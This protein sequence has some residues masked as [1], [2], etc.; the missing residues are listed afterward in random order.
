MVSA[1]TKR[2]RRYGF[3]ATLKP[4]F[5]LVD[6][7]TPESLFTALSEFAHERNAFALPRL[8]VGDL[9]DFLALR[10]EDEC[11]QLDSLA[12]DCVVKFDRFRQRPSKAEFARRSRRLNA[13][14]RDLLE[15]WGYPYVLDQWRFHMTLT[16]S[17]P[18]AHAG[19]IGEFLSRWFEPALREPLWV[20]D[21][22]LFLEEE[23]GREFRLGA[24]FPLARP[25]SLT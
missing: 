8:R 23:S 5:R 9:G 7:E 3:H 20:T 13:R 11:A 22:C 19:T 21:L 24:R 17:V 2:P 12:E 14:Q 10:A 18:E 6:D 1:V 15:Q 16:G 4:P 25:A